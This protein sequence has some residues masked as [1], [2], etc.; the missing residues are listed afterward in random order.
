MTNP[1]DLEALRSWA[2]LKKKHDPSFVM[3]MV[4][5]QY[6]GVF[7]ACP[8]GQYHGLFV[9]PRI[10]NLYKEATKL[11]GW[12]YAVHLAKDTGQ[13]TDYLLEYAHGL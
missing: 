6:H 2:L 7:L 8:R 5:P 10:N 11:R 13:A 1:I 12:G 9:L 4:V 3:L